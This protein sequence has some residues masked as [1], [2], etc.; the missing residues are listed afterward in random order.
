MTTELNPAEDALNKI[1]TAYEA[2]RGTLPLW[3]DLEEGYRRAIVAM[4]FAGANDAYDEA[5]ELWRDTIGLAKDLG[6]D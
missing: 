1:R 2:S 6:A 5:H 4:W 3:D